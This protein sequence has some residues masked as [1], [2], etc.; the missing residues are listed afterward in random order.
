MRRPSRSR[1][2]RPLSSSGSPRPG[3]V[4]DNVDERARTGV[5]RRR[6]GWVLRAFLVVAVGAVVVGCETGTA[7]A[8][9]VVV[10]VDAP[11]ATDVR[12][13]TLR[14]DDGRL[15]TFRVGRLEIT[16]DAFPAAHLREHL[17]TLVPIVVAY[18]VENGELVAIRLA[19]APP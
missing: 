6:V 14:T 8:R 13:F 18:R 9:G 12:G 15:L 10:A 3:S 2:W 1:S 4:A 19:D 11:T 7:T 5:A 17:R 16:G